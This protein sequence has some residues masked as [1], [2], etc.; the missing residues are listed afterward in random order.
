MFYYRIFIIVVFA[1]C[2]QPLVRPAPIEQ[3]VRRFTNDATEDWARPM[4]QSR[5]D[6]DRYYIREADSIKILQLKFYEYHNEQQFPDSTKRKRFRRTIRI[7]T[8]LYGSFVYPMIARHY[9]VEGR[10]TLVFQFDA[11]GQIHLSHIEWSTNSIFNDAATSAITR[12]R[13]FTFKQKKGKP[14]NKQLAWGLIEL[15]WTLK[16]APP[17]PLKQDTIRFWTK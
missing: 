4:L 11:T 10:T 8:S 6:K 17:D 7:D 16:P 2:T 3:N 13:F 12:G 5:N 1:G 15:Q 14:K 9:G